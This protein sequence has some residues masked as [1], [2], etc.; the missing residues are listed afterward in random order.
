MWQ[1]GAPRLQ[2]RAVLVLAVGDGV[3]PPHFM[4]CHISLF[5]PPRVSNV[6]ESL[7]R[8]LAL[9]QM[10]AGENAKVSNDQ[11]REMSLPARY[12]VYILRPQKG[13]GVE[14]LLI[15]TAPKP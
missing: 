5:D 15:F 12:T 9:F 10:T 13:S 6:P 8:I 11:G 4:N 14:A 2:C 3:L 1:L 7:L